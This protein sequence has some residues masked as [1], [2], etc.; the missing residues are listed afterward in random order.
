MSVFQPSTSKSLTSTPLKSKDIGVYRSRS[1]DNDSPEDS[2]YSLLSPI[3]HESFEGSDDDL[4]VEQLQQG[5]NNLR[6]F[7]DEIKHTIPHRHGKSHIQRKVAEVK[8]DK[9]SV[10]LQN[11]SAWEQW[12]VTKAKEER[13]K[14]EQKALEELTLKEKQ[15]LVERQKVQKRKQT[16]G[17][18][19]D[20]LKMKRELERQEKECKERQKQEEVEREKQKQREIELKAQEKYK[21]WLL[22]KKQE[23]NERKE[24]EKEE[25]ALKEAEEMERRRRAEEKF[26]DWLRTQ[27]KNRPKRNTPCPQGFDHLNYPSPSFYNPVPWKPIHV[28][29][30]EKPPQKKTSRRKLR[31]LPKHHSTPCLTFRPKDTLSF[32]CKRR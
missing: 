22:K 29:P 9:S 21:E 8:L 6:A 27:N 13:L 28:P 11:L 16:E 17:K 10:S 3:Y 12:L 30:P 5:L 18:I 2:T 15:E 1:V 26:Q 20:W 25:A 23:E 31:G 14:V 4:D 7:P 19:Q 32:A 24:R